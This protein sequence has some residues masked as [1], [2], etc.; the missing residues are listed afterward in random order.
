[1]EE[2][3][4]LKKHILEGRY[5][6]A[7]AVV[8]DLEGMSRKAILM[9]IKSFLTRLVSHLIKNDAEQRLTN[10]WSGSIRNS[11]V[12][13]QGWNVMGN[14]TGHYVHAD[15]WRELLE[16]VWDTALDEAALEV[17]G[18][19]HSPLQ[20]AEMIDQEAIFQRAQHL[21]SLTFTEST[22]DLP[23]RLRDEMKNLPGGG[24]AG[25]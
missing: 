4:I 8:E 20:L 16:N 5:T 14:H 10:S 7:L 24:E 6:D 17:N 11:I 13:I 19:R 21:L 23:R 12:Q 25:N 15:D 3:A 22:R 2:L 18:G 9:T 1:M